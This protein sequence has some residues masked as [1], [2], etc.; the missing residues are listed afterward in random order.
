ME[1]QTLLLAHFITFSKKL[2]YILY[3]IVLMSNDLKKDY[4]R[5]FKTMMVEIVQF[6]NV[7]KTH[8]G[9]LLK[10]LQLQIKVT[11]LHECFTSFLNCTNAINFLYIIFIN[12]EKNTY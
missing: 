1:Y 12:Q 9:V 3:V 7:K 2:L 6:K 11:L 5:N 10:S 8:G 4:R